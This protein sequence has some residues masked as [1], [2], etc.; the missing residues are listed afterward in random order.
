M[1]PCILVL[2]FLAC[3]HAKAQEVEAAN[4]CYDA[5]DYQCASD[6]YKK[7]IDGKKFDPKDQALILFRIGYSQGELKN[8][9]EAVK[10]LKDAIAADSE[11]GDAYW[12]LGGNYYSLEKYD[13]SIENYTKAIRLFNND[14]QSLKAL[15][16]W[17]GKCYTNTGKYPESRADF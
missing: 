15:Y 17:R 6:N 13:L 9:D 3:V 14:N 5:K 11:F 4:K 12:S 2:F 16:Y 7:A 8:Y 10:Y 1:K